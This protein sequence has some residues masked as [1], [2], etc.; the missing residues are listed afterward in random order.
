MTKSNSNNGSMDRPQ[1]RVEGGSNAPEKNI[2]VYLLNSV[3]LDYS[4][5]RVYEVVHPSPSLDD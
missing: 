2:I 4:V 1:D 5:Y 3:S